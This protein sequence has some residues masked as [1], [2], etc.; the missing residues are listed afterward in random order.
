MELERHARLGKKTK[1][2][3]DLDW[4]SALQGGVE[5]KPMLG[6]TLIGAIL[7]HGGRSSTGTTEGERIVLP[8]E[9]E[10]AIQ[11]Y[12]LVESAC[13][14]RNGGVEI[15]AQLLRHVEL[16][17]SSIPG[18]AMALREG[19]KSAPEIYSALFA[20]PDGPKWKSLERLS[21][22]LSRA[23]W[24]GAQGDLR[25]ERALRLMSKAFGGGGTNLSV[26]QAS[27][28]G[29]A[30]TG[31]HVAGWG[32]FWRIWHPFSA[33]RG[34][35]PY[36]WVLD[37]A[38]RHLESRHWD[39]AAS[40]TA[41]F[42]WLRPLLVILA[43]CAFPPREMAPRVRLLQAMSMYDNI[44]GQLQ[45]GS[46]VLEQYAA[47]LKLRLD[48]A[49]YL[50]K[51]FG[52]AVGGR[53]LESLE[54]NSRLHVLTPYLST[55]RK[56]SILRWLRP[57]P[58]VRRA[59]STMV[60]DF[61]AYTAL[62]PIFRMAAA[63]SSFHSR[64]NGSASSAKKAFS[65][66]K[67]RLMSGHLTKERSLEVLEVAFSLLFLKRSHLLAPINMPSKANPSVEVTPD[68]REAGGAYSGFN[69]VETSPSHQAVSNLMSGDSN[70][71][72]SQGFHIG[73][74]EDGTVCEGDVTLSGGGF[75]V[76]GLELEASLVALEKI[77]AILAPKWLDQ[78]GDQ[79]GDQDDALNVAGKCRFRRLRHHVD[80]ALFR[81]GILK[82]G[83]SWPYSSS[84]NLFQAW[85]SPPARLI[86]A[87]LKWGGGDVEKAQEIADFYGVEMHLGLAIAKAKALGLVTAKR[88]SV[89]SL[90]E[91][92]SEM[93]ISNGAMSTGAESCSIDDKIEGFD[94]EAEIGILLG[95]IS[96]CLSNAGDTYTHGTRTHVPCASSRAELLSRM[97]DMLPET[98]RLKDMHPSVEGLISSVS[99]QGGIYEEEEVHL[100][101]GEH[102]TPESVWDAYENDLRSACGIPDAAETCPELVPASSTILPPPHSHVEAGVAFP[103]HILITSSQSD[104]SPAKPSWGRLSNSIPTIEKVD[105]PC[106]VS[107]PSSLPLSE[108][109]FI[110]SETPSA[111]LAR[112]IRTP[113]LES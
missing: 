57:S 40:T 62:A 53:A 46:T 82:C 31:G 98:H 52:E 29:G 92:L 100:G 3:T 103:P 93:M 20:S 48:L 18:V 54:R 34:V 111:I 106:I 109:G 69:S 25:M 28:S 43:W 37:S 113:N 42:P 19:V 64:K 5:A 11:I 23:R 73:L 12:E 9:D 107:P 91:T 39:A 101:W 63:S 110:S 47:E 59:D 70:E 96:L 81:L 95:D 87:S 41:P 24:G 16:P 104:S 38:L 102:K 15:L 97:M 67:S 74:S 8:S 6:A 44:N 14:M 66:L 22:E 51:K 49:E 89:D 26:I 13:L 85:L 83:P 86:D 72:L 58:L 112:G 71:S 17:P 32:A 76:G 88:E 78:D 1:A 45:G 77:I 30:N 80:C 50:S 84:D 79:D 75:L 90:S 27:T 60:Q 55:L 21:E 7:K 105:S 56:E 2:R 65:S 36:E 68:K 108:G 61:I 94:T 4:L 33:L 10:M 35:H 99:T